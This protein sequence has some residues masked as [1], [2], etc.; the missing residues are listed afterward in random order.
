M[1]RTTIVISAALLLMLAAAC[2]ESRITGTV[3]TASVKGTVVMSGDLNGVDAS[4]IEVRLPGTG[5]SSITNENGQFLIAGVPAGTIDLV[6]LRG[7]GIEET[8]TVS[9]KA[10]S[11]TV[12]LT[13][14]RGRG[15]PVSKP[16]KSIQGSILEV[17]DS[18]IVVDNVLGGET[19]VLVDE[20]TFI[21]KGAV[22][23][24]ISD[25][26]VGDLVHVRAREGEEEGSLVAQ[27]ISVSPRHAGDPRFLPRSAVGQII[28]LGESELTIVTEEGKELLVQVDQRTEIYTKNILLQF[29]DLKEG[30]RVKVFGVE[31]EDGTMLAS[32]IRV[33]PGGGKDEDEG[34]DEDE[35][36][37]NAVHGEVVS[38]AESS[39]VVRDGENLEITVE[40]NESTE[41]RKRGRTVSYGEIAEGTVLTAIGDRL[42]EATLVARKINITK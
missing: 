4:G 13:G 8:R 1:K 21:F 31:R 29:D 6:F 16:G 11:V 35:S 36:L 34:E 3:G 32:W 24:L 19:E 14:R 41:I 7:D 40:V 30:D 9:T 26:E 23:L 15:R 10:E 37:G 27:S 5:V 25:L 28:S 33:K 38:V 17:R 18:S 2:S 20:D 39:F 42:D 22:T 12:E